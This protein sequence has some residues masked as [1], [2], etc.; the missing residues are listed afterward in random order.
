M[1]QVGQ[2]GGFRTQDKMC[3]VKYKDV[4]HMTGRE[5]QKSETNTIK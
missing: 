5:P 4:F 2:D 1:A 3:R